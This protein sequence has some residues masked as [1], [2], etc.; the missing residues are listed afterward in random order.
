MHEIDA[1]SS[2]LGQNGQDC[3]KFFVTAGAQGDPPCKN[4]QKLRIY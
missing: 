2:A 1:I 3:D 4:S